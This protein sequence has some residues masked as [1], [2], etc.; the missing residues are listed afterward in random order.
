[1]A[2]RKKKT[3]KYRVTGDFGD[4]PVGDILDAVLLLEDSSGGS[5][6]LLHPKEMVNETASIE[7]A[8]LV[9]GVYESSCQENDSFGWINIDIRDM[10]ALASNV[11][12]EV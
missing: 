3:V 8:H 5:A 11:L 6:L 10:K 4:R 7:M 12:S 2:F 1:M 9:D